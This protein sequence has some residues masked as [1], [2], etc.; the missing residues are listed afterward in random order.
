MRATKVLTF[1]ISLIMTASVLA[2]PPGQAPVKKDSRIGPTQPVFM[3][4]G[5]LVWTDLD[6]KGAPGVKVASLWGDPAKGRRR[7][8]QASGRIHR[9][10]SHAY[11]CH[12][13]RVPVRHL[14]P[15]AR[16]K[17]GGAAR[18]GLLHDAARW[19]LSAHHLLR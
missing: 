19:K 12:E 2:Q 11:P 17:S 1:S 9:P 4:A 18:S 14:H 7:L 15:G 10:T 8:L 16:G 5:D 13:G 3:A 6:P